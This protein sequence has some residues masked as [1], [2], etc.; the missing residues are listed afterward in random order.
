MAFTHSKLASTTVGVGGAS[1]I[2][3]SNIP[4]NYTDLVIKLS[5]RTVATSD[6]PGIVIRFNGSSASSY[7]YKYINS[8]GTA[9]SSGG[10]SSQTSLRL[11]NT[12]GSAQTTNTF[13]N[14]EVYI[15]NYAG[16]TNKSVSADT[17]GE[18]NGTAG[19]GNLTAG[20]WANTTAINNISI[21][22]TT[23]VNLAQYSTATLYGIR[24]EL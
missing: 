23:P 8:S 1:T 9:Y 10:A 18:N 20:I 5:L 3:F 22:E 6:F 11:G 13:G 21:F 2:T 16:S 19:Y 14:F 4:Q 15:P 12:P 7:S 17:Q 24:V